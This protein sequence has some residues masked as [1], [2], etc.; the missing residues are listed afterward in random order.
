M[1][2]FDLSGPKVAT[3]SSTVLVLLHG[4]GSH[5]GDLQALRPTLPHAW[6]LVTPQA[7]HP[8][9]PW[10]YGPGWAWYRYLGENRVDDET[11]RRS[12]DAI[13]TFLGEIP[14]I[15]G[16]EPDRVLLGGFS[17]GGTTSLAYALTH[18]GAVAAVLNFSGF[19]A[20]A[21]VV[22]ATTPSRASTPVFWG[23]GTRDANIPLALATKGRERLAD[24]GVRLSAHDYDIGHWIV[25]EEVGAAV[26]FIDGLNDRAE[27]RLGS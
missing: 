26:R 8:G 21:P 5:R 13:E 20:S 25:P 27:E 19:L 1:L 24:A 2:G 18:P 23:H 15:V 16:T 14:A 6:T 12:L 4:R 9:H 7:P 22:D 17:Q 11:L 10:G 3:A